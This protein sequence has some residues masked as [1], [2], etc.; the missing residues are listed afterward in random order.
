MKILDRLASIAGNRIAVEVAANLD[1]WT[2]KARPTT[3]DERRRHAAAPVLKLSNPVHEIEVARGQTLTVWLGTID[4][5]GSREQVELRMSLDGTPEIY[6][7]I[8]ATGFDDW[9]APARSKATGTAL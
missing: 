8:P 9:K 4:Q 7:D 3:M 1:R 5:D 2:A 6:S